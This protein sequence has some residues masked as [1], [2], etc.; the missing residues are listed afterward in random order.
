MVVYEIVDARSSRPGRS[1][2]PQAVQH[3]RRGVDELV[4]DPVPEADVEQA[5]SDHHQA[6]H[7]ARAERDL[8]AA[9]QRVAA[10]LG[11]PGG[12]EGRGVH[13][14]EAADAREEATR[15]E[16]D[17]DEGVLD[18]HECQPGQQ[19]GE[20]GED[21]PDDLVLPAQVGQRAFADVLG[22]LLHPVVAGRGRAHHSEQHPGH[23]ER[24][25]RG[26]GGDP[27]H[28][29]DVRRRGVRR[30]R[31]RAGQQGGEAGEGSE[32]E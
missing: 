32:A 24:H 14:D 19:D 11:G 17:G 15:Q 12:R 20:D 3:V 28:H 8:Q 16:G 5:E 26:D 6:H 2:G 23:G 22:D 10:P 29:V 13:A 4:E 25:D 21:D 1:K 31:R 27:P 7:R 18:P 9:V 30:C